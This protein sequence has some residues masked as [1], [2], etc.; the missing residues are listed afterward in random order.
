MNTLKALPQLY[1]II[2]VSHTQED[3]T[4][5][6]IACILET[7]RYNNARDNITGLL[8]YDKQVFFQA[9]EGGRD[10]V[11]RCYARIC[12]DAR[13]GSPYIAW[14]GDVRKRSFTSWEMGYRTPSD[15]DK[16]DEQSVL[17]LT[18]LIAKDVKSEGSDLLI[19]VLIRVLFDGPKGRDLGDA[20][21]LNPNN[22]INRH[23]PK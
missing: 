1:Q 3:T 18:D 4:V 12:R 13:H 7:S 19:S 9:L 22:S 17:A 11:E 5:N 21:T 6:D 23:R 14:Q 8:I 10:A 20:N 16:D 2:Y 15:L